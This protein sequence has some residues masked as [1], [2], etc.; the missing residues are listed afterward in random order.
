[1]DA[2]ELELWNGRPE[3][4]N[5]LYE[6]YRHEIDKIVEATI[7]RMG[8]PKHA[9]YDA[10][11]SA[12]HIG[13]LHAIAKFEVSKGLSFPNF[14]QWRIRGEMLDELRK[15]DIGRSVRSIVNQRLRAELE[16]W[17]KLNREPTQDEVCK[18]LD[19]DARQYL[20]STT[21]AQ[22]SIDT[23]LNRKSADARPTTL[24]DRVYVP[25]GRDLE[26]TFREIT[27]GLSIQEQTILYLYYWCGTSMKQTG[28]AMGLSESRISQMHS[29]LITKLKT[30]AGERFADALRA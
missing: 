9:D 11:V 3:T 16:L 22:S 5:A 27:R 20:L 26:S 12:G 7:Y 19:W 15:S 24:K 23:V 8:L 2:D 14:A 25:T 4:R 17:R 28:A 10:I 21:R 30:T 1:M 6:L 29:D 18:H 13:S